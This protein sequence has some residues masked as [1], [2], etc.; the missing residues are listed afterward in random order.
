MLSSIQCLLGEIIQSFSGGLL[1]DRGR[2]RASAMLVPHTSLPEIQMGEG[3]WGRLG[4][5]NVDYGDLHEV[6][7]QEASSVWKCLLLTFQTDIPLSEQTPILIFYYLNLWTPFFLEDGSLTDALVLTGLLS[8]HIC[9]MW[10]VCVCAC[11]SES[12]YPL[13][14]REKITKSKDG[15]VLQTIKR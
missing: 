12:S 6:S 15:G 2:W 9:V 4:G 7:A 5:E 14:D 11:V 10:C 1:T 3:L 13:L 8:S